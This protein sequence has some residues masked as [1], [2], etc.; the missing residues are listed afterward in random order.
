MSKRTAILIACVAGLA[1]LAAGGSGMWLLGKSHEHQHAA[2]EKPA[3][4][5]LYQ[6]PMHPSVTSDH[7]GDCPIC[8]MKLVK[9]EAKGSGPAPEVAA[10]ESGSVPVPG[11]SE[12][13]IDPARQTI[14]S[15]P[16]FMARSSACDPRP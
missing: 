12:V 2:T 8:G 10:K 3:P 5:P 6:C 7:P 15:R 16:S 4:R 13:N 11:L 14:W 9:V 1:G